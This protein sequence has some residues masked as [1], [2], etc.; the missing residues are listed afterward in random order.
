MATS[1]SQKSIRE[2]LKT[3]ID[4]Q[5][6]LFA[7]SLLPGT[8]NL[9]GVR[10]PVVRSIS[11]DILKQD[12]K[13]YLQ[14]ISCVRTETSLY[15]EE[16]LLEGLVLA[17]CPVSPEERIQKIRNFLP[18]IQ[19]W[20]VCDSF[21]A[22][23][24]E[25]RRFPELY[26]PFLLECLSSSQEFIVRFALV[27]LLDHFLCEKNVLELAEIAASVSLEHYYA[28]MAAAWLLAECYIKN[29]SL[30]EEM[31]NQKDISPFIRKKAIQK[32][33]ESQKLTAEEKER[34]RAFRNARKDP[35]QA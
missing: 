31:L 34:L 18:L 16:I 12:W 30:P 24:K 35:Q 1:V 32:A 6:C 25:A 27:M 11:K 5:Y 7:S 14:E 3:C 22:T 29:P 2:Q 8:D 4:P 17:Q 26:R 15:F 19:N 13:N 23:L 28:Q 10:L 20:S 9:L 21:C 33:L